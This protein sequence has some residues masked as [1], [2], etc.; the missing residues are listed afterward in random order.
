MS[1]NTSPKQALS[2][3]KHHW[4]FVCLRTLNVLGVLATLVLISSISIEAFTGQV[5]ANDSIFTR[6]QLWVCLYFLLDFLLQSLL[7]PKRLRFGIRHIAL[8]L[9]SIPYLS[10]ID[11]YSLHLSNEVL[12]LTKFLPILRGGVALIVIVKMLVSNAITGLL[13]AYII[14]FFSIVYF[15]TL[16]FF[17]FESAVNPDVSAYSDAVWWAAMTVTTVGSEILPVTTLGKI[18][19]TVVAIVGMTTFPIFTAYITSL[20]QNMNKAKASR[21]AD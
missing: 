12:Y 19:T 11:H 5:F 20:I 2:S 4:R 21:K 8:V 7:A 17:I 1:L 14:S 16:I 15:Q 9:L 18:C 6:I 10:L 13:I 3:V